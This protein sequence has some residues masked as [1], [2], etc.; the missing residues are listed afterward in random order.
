MPLN[1]QFGFSYY[2]GLDYYKNKAHIDT[3][4]ARHKN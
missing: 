4:N 1:I 3:V 2:F